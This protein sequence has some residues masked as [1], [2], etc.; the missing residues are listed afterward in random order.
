MAE[1]WLLG[2][3]RKQLQ[4]DDGALLAVDCSQAFVNDVTYF[5]DVIATT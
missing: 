3:K 1:E 5:N 2:E 4:I